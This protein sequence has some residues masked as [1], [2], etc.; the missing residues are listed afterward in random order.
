MLKKADI[1]QYYD[2]N[3]TK[4]SLKY[5]NAL[6]AEK[7][8]ICNTIKAQQIFKTLVSKATSAMVQGKPRNFF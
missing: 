4:L 7:I 3:K 2:R 6:L 5:R 1:Y 8:V